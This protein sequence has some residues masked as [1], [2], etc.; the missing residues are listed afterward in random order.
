MVHRKDCRLYRKWWIVWKS[1]PCKEL[2]NEVRVIPCD[3]DAYDC[4]MISYNFHLL[5]SI[6]SI[7][8]FLFVFSSLPSSV[9]AGEHP[10]GSPILS[11]IYP[12]DSLSVFANQDI[13]VLGKYGADKR[14]FVKRGTLLKVYVLPVEGDP[15][16]GF[17][18]IFTSHA[19]YRGY[20]ETMIGDTLTIKSKKGKVI[21]FDIDNLYK[22]KVYNEVGARVFGDMI[23]LASFIG[24]G[25]S[26]LFVGVVGAWL[27]EEG[28]FTDSLAI[29]IMAIG[30]GIGCLSYLIHRL[31]LLI[32]RSKYDLIDDWYIVRNI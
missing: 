14:K 7:G 25:Y 20:F 13:L 15:K 1:A 9:I 24:I 21:K 27:L 16:G 31:G 10:Y 30:V 5:R 22:L 2:F 12:E 4:L 29:P 8:V 18:N 11:P 19:F 26:G 6:S 28:V 17:R 32:R 23:N 3:R